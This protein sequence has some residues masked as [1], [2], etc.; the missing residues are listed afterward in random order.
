MGAVSMRGLLVI[1]AVAISVS[2]GWAKV[3][4][5]VGGDRGWDPSTNVA[6]WSSGK[7]FRV[8]DK[9]WFTYSAASEGIAEVKSK[10]EFE[11]CDIS[12]PIRMYMD[13]LDKVALDS[14]GPRYFASSR[15]DS[16]K[17]GLKLHVEVQQQSDTN[18][19]TATSASTVHALAA[20]PTIPSRSSTIQAS[21]AIIWSGLALLCFMGFGRV[22]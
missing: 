15:S 22:V 6:D 4:H 8:G 9:I 20:A 10:D 18:N 11:S 16:C 14:A 5:V 13:G 3:H 21:S 7:I 12:N 19:Q 17:N 2:D 1:L